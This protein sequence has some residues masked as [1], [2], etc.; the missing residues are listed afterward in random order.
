MSLRLALG[1]LLVCSVEMAQTDIDQTPPASR[2]VVPVVGSV[3][4]VNDVHWRTDVELRND[5]KSEVTVVLTMPA[6]PDANFVMLPMDAGATLHLTDVA[7]ALGVENGLS[8]LVVQTNARRSVN[9]FATAYG[10][11]GTDSFTPQPIAINYGST[12]FPVRVLRELSFSTD[13]RTNLGLV[14][15]GQTAADFTLA[16]QRVPGRNLAVTR[17]LLPPNALWHMSIQAA[18]PLI[19]D[20]D[21][22]AVV[23]E[24]PSPDTYIYASVIENA[25]NVARF[26]QPGLG[27]PLPPAQ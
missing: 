9:V 18:F 17:I 7:A 5:S 25:T 23:V 21:H 19:T 2:V 15:L 13:Y 22:F 16:L 11:R 6:A 20:G 27:A 12:Y 10:T 14:N 24:T 26:V 3:T 8:P 1:L 4:G